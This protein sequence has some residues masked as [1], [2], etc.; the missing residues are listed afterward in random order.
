MRGCRPHLCSS[1]PACLPACAQEDA[2]LVFTL[3]D[4]RMVEALIT[5]ATAVNVRFVDLWS[6]LLDRMEDHLTA[7]RRC[8]ARCTRSQSEGACGAPA[9]ATGAVSHEMPRRAVP[10]HAMPWGS[11]IPHKKHWE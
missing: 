2:L 10:C 3:V 1:L 11:C 5:A 8:G 6:Q 7:Q 9:M 4:P